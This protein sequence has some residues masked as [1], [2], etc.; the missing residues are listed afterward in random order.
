MAIL[1]RDETTACFH[2]PTIFGRISDNRAKRRSDDHRRRMPFSASTAIA[3]AFD[4]P[5][6]PRISNREMSHSISVG[7]HKQTTT[8]F[9]T[10][11][12]IVHRHRCTGRSPTPPRRKE[13]KHSPKNKAQATASVRPNTRSPARS[14]MRLFPVL[15]SI[16][17]IVVSEIRKGIRPGNK[18]EAADK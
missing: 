9:S 4:R 14:D 17:Q 10:P 13:R 8:T 2:A 5:G 1:R 12:G 16:S 7:T 11:A 18:A 3:A 6:R 15:R